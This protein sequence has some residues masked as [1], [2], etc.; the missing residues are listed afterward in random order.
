M[1]KPPAWLSEV[2]GSLPSPDSIGLLVRFMGMR[3]GDGTSSTTW[4][5]LTILCGGRCR[6]F[7]LDDGDLV[8]VSNLDHFSGSGEKMFVLAGL[9]PPTVYPH[10]L[11]NGELS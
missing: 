1:I 4:H 3:M 10:D 5:L 8:D 2:F 7:R 11:P 6:V 9:T